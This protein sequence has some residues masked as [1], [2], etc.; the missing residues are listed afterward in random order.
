MWVTLSAVRLLAP[1]LT[2][3]SHRDVLALARHRG[4]EASESTL[5]VPALCDGR[6]QRAS[7]ADRATGGRQS[8]RART[9]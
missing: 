6:A 9:A 1:H 8:P 5:A 4:D 2:P 7:G 3:E